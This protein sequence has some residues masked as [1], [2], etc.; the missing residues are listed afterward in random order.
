MPL[1]RMPAERYS[2]LAPLSA[3][4]RTTL[5]MS[6]VHF[7]SPS[8]YKDNCAVI[9]KAPDATTIRPLGASDFVDYLK[10]KSILDDPRKYAE[11][12]RQLLD[13]MAATGI[14][15]EMGQGSDVMMPKLFYC[16]KELTTLQKAGICWLAPALGDD[17]LFHL[18]APAI[19]HITGLNN[20]GDV[21]AG[22][23]IVFD[24]HHILTCAHVVNDMTVDQLQSFQDVECTVDEH[25]VHSKRDVA[26]VRV[27]RPL[28]PVP[29]LSFLSPTIAQPV[30]TVGYPKIPFAREAALTIQR[31]E[32]TN[33]SVTTLD[34]HRVFLYSAIA[35]PGNSGGPIVASDGYVVGVS[36][37]DLSRQDKENAFSPH[38]AGIPTHEIANC[39]DDLDVDVQIPI[40]DFS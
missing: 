21:C 37:Q 38:Y 5:A 7:F 39:L 26:V 36:M 12:I 19:V 33:E 11:R 31:G 22:T 30:F 8:A 6:A 13:R 25:F 28:Q 1:T 20:D 27:N 23:G 29:G 40:E 15:I 3:E 10:K 17:F 18:V 32:I 9:S 16:L 4:L 14:L 24:P 34:G 2:Q 35:R